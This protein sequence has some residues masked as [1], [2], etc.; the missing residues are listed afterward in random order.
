MRYPLEKATSIPNSGNALYLFLIENISIPTHMSH[1]VWYNGCQ[2]L[3]ENDEEAFQGFFPVGKTFKL[4]YA[5]SPM[6]D[7]TFTGEE[8]NPVFV[9]DL[10]S[11]AKL[12]LGIS[13]KAKDSDKVFNPFFIPYDNLPESTKKSNELPALSLAK[14]ISA[15]L[16]VDNIL[17]T[18][19]NVVDMLMIAIRDANSNAMRTILHG[20]HIAW[21]AARFMAF[22]TLEEDIKKNFYGQN[23]IN[24]YVKDIGTVMPAIL[25]TLA[26]LGADPVEVIKEL[27][28]DLYG[29]EAAAINMQKFLYINKSQQKIA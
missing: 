3:I 20:N 6:G 25:Y 18:E 28:Y 22:G 8:K 16:S 26:L 13:G 15:F 17:F 21:C 27:D 7:Y 19:K 12:R 4:S 14:S 11:E 23:D 10:S 5:G 24:F 1:D 29:I 2:K 9:R